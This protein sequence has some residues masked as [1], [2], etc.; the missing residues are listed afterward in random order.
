MFLFFFYFSSDLTING[1]FF[2]DATM[3]KIHQD[4][5]SFNFLY[6]IPQVIYSS[7]LSLIISSLIK[8][9]S[10][11]GDNIMEIREEKRRN[12][13]D[14]NAKLKKLYKILK[15]KFAL[16]FSVTFI[17]LVMFWFYITCFC[18]IYKNTQTHLI[19]DSIL[20]FIMSLIYPFV[21]FLLPS[22]F[23]IFSLIAE[24]KDKAL[25]YKFSQFL[26]NF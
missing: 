16:F 17:I 3:H 18:G 22:F 1:F 2:T 6:Q 20:S 23:R 7:I 19:K 15:I 13:K 25:L 8:Y 24:K 9:L 12:S 26:E 21:T 4:K 5:G 10:S 14:I 11:S